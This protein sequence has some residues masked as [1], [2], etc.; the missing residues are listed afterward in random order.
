LITDASTPKIRRVLAT[1]C[2]NLEMEV[3]GFGEAAFAQRSV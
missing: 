1:A 2:T 3:S